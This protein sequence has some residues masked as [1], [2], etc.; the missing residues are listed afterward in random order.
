[1]SNSSVMMERSLDDIISKR[2]SEPEEKFERKRSHSHR[3]ERHY[4]DLRWNRTWRDRHERKTYGQYSQRRTGRRSYDKK[5]DYRRD[6]KDSS[7]RIY[8]SDLP[9]NVTNKDLRVSYFS[10]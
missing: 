2:K 6:L 3:I 10:L 1:M 7:S 4:T 9:T 8:I 5:K